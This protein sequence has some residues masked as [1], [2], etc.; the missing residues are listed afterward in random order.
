M[1]LVKKDFPDPDGP[2]MNLLRLVMIPRFIGMSL[3]S[4]CTGRPARSTILMPKGE[5]E[6]L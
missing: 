2:R 5:S 1:W 6:D 4:R 3:M